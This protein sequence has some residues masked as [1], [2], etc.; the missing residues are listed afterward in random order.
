MERDKNGL[1]RL[2]I[3]RVAADDA[4][5][6]KCRAYNEH[7]ED[8]CQAEL[9]YDCMYTTIFENNICNKLYV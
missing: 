4:G 7:G 5:T 6:Y 3:G 9:I 8:V 2:T 1:L